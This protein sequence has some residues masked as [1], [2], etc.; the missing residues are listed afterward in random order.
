MLEV[1]VSQLELWSIL[2]KI[3]NLEKDCSLHQQVRFQANV[4]LSDDV[5]H[6]FGH[7]ARASSSDDWRKALPADISKPRPNGKEQKDAL[8]QPGPVA[9]RTIL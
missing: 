5:T 3:L 9:W 7:V 2:E 1:Y 4:F 8:E 6:L